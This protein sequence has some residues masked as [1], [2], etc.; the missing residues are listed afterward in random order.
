MSAFNLKLSVSGKTTSV[1]A[2]FQ[3]SKV[4]ELGGPYT[5]LLDVQPRVAKKD[6]RLHESRNLIGFKYDGHDYPADP[7]DLFYCWLYANAL[8]QN[9]ELFDEACEFDAF[10][11][12]EF[13]P[14][15]Q[16]N[17]Q[18]KALAAAVGL[19]RAGI[20]EQAIES[21]AAFRSLAYEDS[22]A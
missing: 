21:A 14:A 11:D 2:A 6:I 22:G 5:D 17:C 13:N 3:S 19:H 15:R 12:I 9:V 1:E 8:S 10:A 20:F 4:F 16:I 18:A 7:K